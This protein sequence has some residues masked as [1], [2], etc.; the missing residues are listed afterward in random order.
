MRA[1]VNKME[2]GAGGNQIVRRGKK[3]RE[4]PTEWRKIETCI[5]KDACKVLHLNKN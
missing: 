5:P 4:Q 2:R 3:G 1:R